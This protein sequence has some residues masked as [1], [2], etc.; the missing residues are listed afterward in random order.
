MSW[1]LTSAARL[2]RR[3]AILFVAVFLAGMVAFGLLPGERRPAPSA[4]AAPAA[5]F[6]FGDDVSVIL[7]HLGTFHFA[8]DS[9]K[10]TIVTTYRLKASQTGSVRLSNGRVVRFSRGTKFVA[11]AQGAGHQ[12]WR[13][14]ASLEPVSAAVVIVL[15]YA[16]TPESHACY[17]RRSSVRTTLKPTGR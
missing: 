10:R 5:G 12:V 2:G 17:V 7:P 3:S 15:T 6:P 13:L 14:R 1:L 16:F 8:C 4:L 11:P 9:N